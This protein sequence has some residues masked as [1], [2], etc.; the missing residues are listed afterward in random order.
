MAIGLCQLLPAVQRAR[1]SG[2]HLRIEAVE[3][4]HA[5]TPEHIAGRIGPMKGTGVGT[6]IAEDETA[7]PIRV[8]DVEVRMAH[9]LAHRWQ[10]LPTTITGARLQG[11][12]FIEHQFF[13]F[14]LS[15]KAVSYTH[16]RAHETRHD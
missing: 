8:A 7:R 5:L 2:G 1:Q 4:D 3:F 14:E 12:P 11:K 10:H 16:L 15:M 13:V 9:Q 6:A